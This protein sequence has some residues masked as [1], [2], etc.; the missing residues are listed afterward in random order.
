MELMSKMAEQVPEVTRFTGEIGTPGGVLKGI[1]GFSV[2]MGLEGMPVIEQFGNI[3]ETEEGAIVTEFREPLVDVMEEEGQF[4]IVA[5]LPGIEEQD[6][7]IQVNDG[8][9]EIDAG[10]GDR[11]YRKEILLSASVDPGS[12]ESSYRNGVLEIRLAR[13]PQ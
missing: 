13:G 12:L 3:Q 8:I 7:Q 2:R 4:R 11:T 10:A 9:L 6:I 1:Y 5:E